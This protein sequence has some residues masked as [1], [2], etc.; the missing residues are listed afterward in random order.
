MDS[1]FNIALALWAFSAIMGIVYGWL[2]A[3]VVKN[4]KGMATALS[5]FFVWSTA[6][7]G[8]IMYAKEKHHLDMDFGMILIAVTICF[9]A[10]TFFTNP[11]PPKRRA[12]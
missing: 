8:F 7:L 11:E 5:S 3:R 2:L 10:F 12:L 1:Y 4:G 9:F 6:I